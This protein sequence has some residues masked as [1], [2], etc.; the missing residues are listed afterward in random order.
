MI[1]SLPDLIPLD[2][3]FSFFL[4]S[5]SVLLHQNLMKDV[6]DAQA[7]N[8]ERYEVR[9]STHRGNFRVN[10]Q[11]GSHIIDG[12]K[13]ASKVALVRSAASENRRAV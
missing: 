3:I 4:S 13:L 1:L 9:F 10:N 11:S 2:F 5:L 6:L 12:L 7:L 8:F